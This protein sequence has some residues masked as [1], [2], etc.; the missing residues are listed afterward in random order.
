MNS[1]GSDT[2]CNK[3]NAAFNDDALINPEFSDYHITLKTMS[4]TLFLK[5][6]L[7]ECPEEEKLQ[8]LI[9]SFIWVYREKLLYNEIISPVIFL[10]V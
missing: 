8:R 5:R 2:V 1:H 3:I 7:H 9:R 4:E 10:C 6:Y